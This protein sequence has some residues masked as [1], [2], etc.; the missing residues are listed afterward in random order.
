M[1]ECHP[2]IKVPFSSKWYGLELHIP[3]ADVV[4]MVDFPD[5]GDYEHLGSPYI[6][7]VPNPKHVIAWA[8]ENK[9]LIEHLSLCLIIGCWALQNGN[10]YDFDLEKLA[11]AIYGVS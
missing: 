8:T 1:K 9:Y 4:E 11:G 5:M 3:G 7:H 6:D 10:Q 2:V